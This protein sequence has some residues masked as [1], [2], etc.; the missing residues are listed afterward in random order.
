[1]VVK[2]TTAELT[3]MQLGGLGASRHR[4]DGSAEGEDPWLCDPGFRRVCLG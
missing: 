1:M 4:H 3:F 2:S